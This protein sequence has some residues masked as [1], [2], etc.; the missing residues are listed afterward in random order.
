MEEKVQ[1]TTTDGEKG[2]SRKSK[3]VW[4]FEMQMIHFKCFKLLNQMRISAYANELTK[5]KYLLQ[6]RKNGGM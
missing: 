2:G 6:R 5:F 3:W 4:R 1:V